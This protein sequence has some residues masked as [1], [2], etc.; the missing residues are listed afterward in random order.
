MTSAPLWKSAKHE[1]D[2]GTHR[3]SSGSWPSVR[4]SDFE[5]GPRASWLTPGHSAIVASMPTKTRGHIEE[6]P[7]RTPT[8]CPRA[9][10]AQLLEAWMRQCVPVPGTVRK[11]LQE[12][13]CP[14]APQKRLLAD[15]D[16]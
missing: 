13:L 12:P 11:V 1:L 6:E 9:V 7:V 3:P 8:T 4:P 14:S 16:Q 10:D 15:K 5:S 2:T